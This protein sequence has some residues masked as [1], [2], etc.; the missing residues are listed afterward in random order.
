MAHRLRAVTVSKIQAVEPAARALRPLLRAARPRMLVAAVAHF[1]ARRVAVAAALAAV[2]LA[3][4]LA[5][6]ALPIPAVVV[7]A[8]ALQARPAGQALLS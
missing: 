5:L 8:V 1:K 4:R 7:A 2:E 6:R 3:V